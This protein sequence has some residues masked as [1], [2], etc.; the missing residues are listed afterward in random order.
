MFRFF[1]CFSFLFLLFPFF[2]QTFEINGKV[3]VKQKKPIP[4]AHVMNLSDSLSVVCDV[5]G[6]FKMTIGNLATVLKASSVGFESEV[7]NFSINNYKSPVTIILKEN[8]DILK[9]MVISG[10][11]Q[12]IDRMESPIPIAVYS[13]Q[14]LNAVPSPSL[15][16]ATNQIS[17]L[18]PQFN[19]SVCNTGDVHINGME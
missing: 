13:A 18:R 2:S 16:Q 8:N 17:G 11:L 9:E 15:V 14:F 19:C 12:L 6:D 7:L 5:K 4:F 10:T 1:I 3:I